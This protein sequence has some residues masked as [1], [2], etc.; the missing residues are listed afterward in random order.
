MYPLIPRFPDPAAGPVRG[1]SAGHLMTSTTS[2]SGDGSRYGVDTEMYFT[3]DKS[4]SA[5]TY[6]LKGLDGQPDPRYGNKSNPP[7]EDGMEALSHHSTADQGPDGT[8]KWGRHAEPA[9]PWRCWKEVVGW[10]GKQL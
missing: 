7:I 6:A 4:P 10:D 9:V 5:A 3:V 8:E 2:I 1:D